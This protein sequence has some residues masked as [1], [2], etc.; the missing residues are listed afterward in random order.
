M[1]M[2]FGILEGKKI[3]DIIKKANDVALVIKKKYPFT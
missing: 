1:E 3:E 2:N